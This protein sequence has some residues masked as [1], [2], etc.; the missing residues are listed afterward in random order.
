MSVSI[1]R[2]YWDVNASYRRRPM[3]ECLVNPH[4]KLLDVTLNVVK[5][6]EGQGS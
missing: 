5:G 3:V 6:L 1:P 2:A 4:G